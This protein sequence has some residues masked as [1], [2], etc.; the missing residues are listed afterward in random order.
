MNITYIN[1]VVKYNVIFFPVRIVLKKFDSWIFISIKKSYSNSFKMYS[2]SRKTISPLILHVWLWFSRGSNSPK[3]LMTPGLPTWLHSQKTSKRSLKATRLPTS[4]MLHN[5]ELFIGREEGRE[6]DWWTITLS[7]F[8][9]IRIISCCI[10][11]KIGR[12]TLITLY[13]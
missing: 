8:G 3:G 2:Q 1:S 4:R 11:I 5:F 12:N 7:L 10:N 13:K 9:R 6:R